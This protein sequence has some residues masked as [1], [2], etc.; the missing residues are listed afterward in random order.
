MKRTNIFLLRDN[1]A[2]YI[3]EVNETESPLMVY[4]FKK[5]V[6]IIIPAKESKIDSDYKRFY[7]FLKGKESGEQIVDSVRRNNKERLYVKKL[8]KQNEKNSR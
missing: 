8:R 4:K 5:P 3:A 6:A 7:G 1:L 2:K